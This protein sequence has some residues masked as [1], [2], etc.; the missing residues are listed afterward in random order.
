VIEGE[1]DNFIMRDGDSFDA[2]LNL[3]VGHHISKTILVN[4]RTYFGAIKRENEIRGIIL[5]LGVEYR[6]W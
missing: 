2:G 4:F 1:S 3:G 5:N 6:I